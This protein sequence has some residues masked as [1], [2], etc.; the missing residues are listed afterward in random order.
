MLSRLNRDKATALIVG[1]GFKG[2]E[3]ACEL[4]HYPRA[5]N[6]PHGLVAALPCAALHGR[7]DVLRGIH[8][9]RW[10]RYVLPGEVRTQQREVLDVASTSTAFQLLHAAAGAQPD[11]ARWRR[12]G[13]PQ[14]VA[15]GGD[16][17]RGALGCWCYLRRRRLHTGQRGSS[18]GQIH[19][20]ASAEDSVPCGAASVARIEECHGP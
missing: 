20:R 18:A 4:A 3:W 17:E 13:H 11:R 1:A 8:E 5:E 7:R 19:P 14:P 12:M 15:P 10:H 2:V 9:K 6:H 16:A